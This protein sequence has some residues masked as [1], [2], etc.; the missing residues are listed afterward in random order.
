MNTTPI[1]L[2]RIIGTVLSDNDHRLLR[3]ATLDQ[4]CSELL[5]AD[6]RRHGRSAAS[7]HCTLADCIAAY[8]EVNDIDPAEYQA[9]QDAIGRATATFNMIELLPA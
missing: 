8:L 4:L 2:N 1:E 6:G 9:T 7:L 5:A 3:L